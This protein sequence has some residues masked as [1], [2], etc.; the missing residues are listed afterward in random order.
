MTLPIVEVD[1]D[2]EEYREIYGE[3]L[4][5]EAAG[6]V[7]PYPAAWIA[8]MECAGH[9]VDLQ[10]GDIH[11]DARCAFLDSHVHGTVVLAATVHLLKLE[12][13]VP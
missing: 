11:L 8:A 13:A 2:S 5:W 1:T 4:A 12:G 6:G 10:N 3:L 7:L 9:V